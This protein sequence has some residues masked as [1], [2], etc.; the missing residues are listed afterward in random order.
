MA[1]QTESNNLSECSVFFTDFEINPLWRQ[2]CVNTR[3]NSVVYSQQL[4]DFLGLL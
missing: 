4:P 2:V 1:L 3:S